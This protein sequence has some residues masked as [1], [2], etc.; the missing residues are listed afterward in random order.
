MSD[1]EMHKPEYDE[2]DVHHVLKYIYFNNKYE[3]IFTLSVEGKL[4]NAYTE[5]TS[6]KIVKNIKLPEGDKKQFLEVLNL[7][8]VNNVSEE[9]IAMLT[10]LAKLE[11]QIE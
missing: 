7:F 8:L 9:R 5:D 4:S 11:V 2:P 1:V 6:G 10:K 3:F